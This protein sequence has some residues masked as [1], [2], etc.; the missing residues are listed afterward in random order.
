MS[1]SNAQSVAIDMAPLP[2]NSSY[3]NSFIDASHHD[4]QNNNQSYSNN[5]EAARQL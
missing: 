2:E 1:S 4:Q 3:S 5:N